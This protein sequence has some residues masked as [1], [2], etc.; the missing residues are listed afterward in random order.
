[1][2]KV[3]YSFIAVSGMLFT[4]MSVQAQTSSQPQLKIGVFDIDEM[5]QAMP[6]YAAVDSMVQIYQRDSLAAEYQFYNSEY[7][8]LDSTFKAD[9]ASG[10]PQT[11]LNLE[12]QQK[13]Q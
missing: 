10:K 6:G 8:R 4:A 12:A 2:K 3:L 1:M 9:S 5:V 13:Q 11:I 7:R